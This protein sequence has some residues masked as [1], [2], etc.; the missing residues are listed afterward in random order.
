MPRVSMRVAILIAVCAC[1]PGPGDH[2]A[3]LPGA[4]SSLACDHESIVAASGPLYRV[5]YDG[6]VELFDP[7]APR[8]HFGIFAMGG[9]S[10]YVSDVLAVVAVTRGLPDRTVAHGRFAG[11][12][13]ADSSRVYWMGT[14]DADPAMRLRSAPHGGSEDVS[15]PELNDQSWL[16]GQDADSLYTE[17]PE[18]LYR[19]SKSALGLV[20]Q[21]WAARYA[22]GVAT[23][24]SEIVWSDGQQIWSN[25]RPGGAPRSLATWPGTLSLWFHGSALLGYSARESGDSESGDLRLTSSIVQI[26]GGRADEVARIETATHWIPYTECAAGVFWSRGRDL[27]RVR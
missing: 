7:V 11:A 13:L 15:G 8:A 20:A 12:I 5:G 27:Y 1:G 21:S 16:A 10:V 17:D 2:L 25:D 18:H 26:G 6:R 22:M 4:I 14:T 19:R 24:A 23:N 9:G 3:T